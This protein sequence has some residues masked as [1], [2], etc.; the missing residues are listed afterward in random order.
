MTGDLAWLRDLGLPVSMMAER[1]GRTEKAVT[2]ELERDK[3][4]ED[5]Q[6]S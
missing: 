3:Q 1:I 4:R 6:E 5:G 2:A